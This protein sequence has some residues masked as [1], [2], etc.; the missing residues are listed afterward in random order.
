M[1]PN[2]I[3]IDDPTIQSQSQYFLD[4]VLEHQ[5]STGWLGPEVNTTKPRYLWGRYPF[6]FG[7]IQMVE[8]NPSQ[9][10]RVVPALHKFVKLANAMIQNGTGLEDWTNTRWEDFVITL[11]W[12][13]LSLS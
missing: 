1:V 8:A 2:G 10:E 13:A 4:Y 5:D 7:A 6:F 11:Q 12:Y 3:L 9:A